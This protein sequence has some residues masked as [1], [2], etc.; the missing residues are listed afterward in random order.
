IIGRTWLDADQARAGDALG[1]SKADRL[2]LRDLGQGEFYGFGPALDHAGVERFRS[3][4]VRTTHPRPGERHLLTAPA[5]SRA[6]RGVLAKF[7]DLPRAAEEEIRDLDQARRC[8]AELERQVHAAKSGVAAKALDQATIAEAVSAAAGR[9]RLVWQRKLGQK[10]AAIR[11][12]AAAMT[13]TG[14]SLSKLR[15]L[16][17]EAERASLA[18]PAVVPVTE[19]VTNHRHERR[20]PPA[21]QRGVPADN[22]NGVLKLAAGERRI[23]TALAQYP[24]GRSKGAGGAADRLRGHRRRLQQLSGRAPLARP[25]RR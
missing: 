10:H 5:P 9:E 22:L 7:A 18:E 12:I 14:Q 13:V 8:I 19:V 21:G 24:A 4:A 1:L 25:N 3:D 17:E 20:T 16:V 11:R 23:L 2:K 6:L 15:E